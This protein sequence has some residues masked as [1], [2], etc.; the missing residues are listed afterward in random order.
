MREG[1][2]SFFVP[3][4]IALLGLA[5]LEIASYRVCT[6]RGLGFDWFDCSCVGTP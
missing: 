1:C 4:I 6:K 5:W 2:G 3:G